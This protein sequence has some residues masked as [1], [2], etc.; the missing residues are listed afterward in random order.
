MRALVAEEV[1]ALISRSIVDAIASTEAATS[2][3][4]TVAEVE[5]LYYEATTAAA[6]ESACSASATPGSTT[7]LAS[8]SGI[9]FTPETDQSVATTAASSSVPNTVQRR[10][11]QLQYDGAEESEGLDGYSPYRPTP[12]VARA[13]H[14]DQEDPAERCAEKIA[15][16]RKSI[17]AL[18]R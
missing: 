8:G 11:R 9:P 2:G 18:R 7:L 15:A 16:M 4:E 13:A 12:R 14:S 10:Q 17:A 3:V 6:S 5:R 1:G